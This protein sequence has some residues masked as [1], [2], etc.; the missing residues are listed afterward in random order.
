MRTLHPLTPDRVG[1]LLGA[2]S[3]CAFWQT[4]PQGD[5]G[6]GSDAGQALRAWVEQVGAEWGPPGRVLYVDD[7]PVGHVVLAPARLVPRLATF[8]TAPSDPAAVVLVTASLG[9]NGQ[10]RLLM[11][12]AA[13]E[14]LAHGARSIDVVAAR[15]LAVARHGCVLEVSGLDRLGFHV[16]REH[17]TYPRLRLDLR[18]VVTIRDE[19]AAYVASRLARLPG[20]RPAPET[21][22]DGATRA[23]RRHD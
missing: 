8:A 9:T 20:L 11:Q 12:A 3:P 23:R 22:P 17:P 2:C 6:H 1:D 16:E 7:A 15:P 19:A 10:R 13:K 14:A 21:R 18:T 5:G 4:G